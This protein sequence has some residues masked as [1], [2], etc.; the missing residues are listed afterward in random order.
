MPKRTDIKSILVIGAGPIGL[1]VALF[2][3]ASGARSVISSEVSP[4]RRALAVHEVQ[5]FG[6]NMVDQ[7]A[8][9]AA[10]PPAAPEGQA[11]LGASRAAA[12]RAGMAAPDP[13]H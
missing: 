11:A 2:A 10:L 3:R 12:Q 7:P 9:P 1:A 8:A 6:A 5:S 13:V 4:A